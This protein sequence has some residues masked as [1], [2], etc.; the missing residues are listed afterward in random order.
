[1][2]EMRRK[3]RRRR[4]IGKMR[5]MMK[6]SCLSVAD[7]IEKGAA[8]WVRLFTFEWQELSILFSKVKM[9]VWYEEKKSL[10]RGKLRAFKYLVGSH[11]DWLWVQS[12][13]LSRLLRPCCSLPCVR[14]GFLSQSL[15]TT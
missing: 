15:W 4:S 13:L 5:K 3:K 12:A 1:M 11:L 6:A 9:C 2:T 8:V 7:K 10:D 14:S